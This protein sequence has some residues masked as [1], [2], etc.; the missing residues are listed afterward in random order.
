M[1]VLESF[2]IDAGRRQSH[3]MFNFKKVSPVRVREVMKINFGEFHHEFHHARKHAAS[4]RGRNLTALL[5][6][7]SCVVRR[8]HTIYTN[9]KAVRSN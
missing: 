7:Q 8:G 3:S 4:P 5:K 9:C 1:R 6:Q 2:G